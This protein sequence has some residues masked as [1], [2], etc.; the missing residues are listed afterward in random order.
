M[1]GLRKK[2]RIKKKNVKW[3]LQEKE[4]VKDEVDEKK[5]KDVKEKCEEEKSVDQ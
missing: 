4:S 2:I 5:E 1:K 3:G